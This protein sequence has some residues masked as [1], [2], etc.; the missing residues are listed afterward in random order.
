MAV[1]TTKKLSTT[2]SS[3]RKASKVRKLE[4]NVDN[5]TDD[6]GSK[7]EVISNT[8]SS[9]TQPRI[10]QKTAL[11]RVLARS[12]KCMFK[13][14]P[15][16]F[17]MD[18][19]VMT[20][21]Y[22]WH[23]DKDSEETLAHFGVTYVLR[24]DLE[25]LLPGRHVHGNND[26]NQ[27]EDVYFGLT[28][29]E[30]SLK[31]SKSWMHPLNTL[32]YVELGHWFLMVIPVDEHIIYHFDSH[33]NVEDIHARQGTLKT[34]CEVLMEIIGSKDY[35]SDLLEGIMDFKS[36]QLKEPRGIPNTGR[37]LMKMLCALRLQL[38]CYVGHTMR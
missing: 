19:E 26:F 38:H 33:L 10:N 31:F 29:E 22:L 34:L 1:Q 17:L 32:K 11:D 6:N 35:Q 13:P 28:T 36:W 15:E 25:S 23:K 4:K 20:A 24:K 37:S 9:T 14:T 16:M 27:Q 18:S 30:L 3:T 12:V 2:P 21:A 7:I 8:K 5:T